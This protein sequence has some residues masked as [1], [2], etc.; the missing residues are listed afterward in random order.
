MLAGLLL[1]GGTGVWDAIMGGKR[2]ARDRAIA[3]KTAEWKSF[4]GNSIP[5]IREANP[6]ASIM[7]GLAGG[8][9]LGNDFSNGLSN[10]TMSDL[11]QKFQTDKNSMMSQQAQW[12]KDHPDATPTVALGQASPGNGWMPI[13]PGMPS[14]W[15][16]PYNPYRNAPGGKK[17]SSGDGE[18]ATLV[19][20]S[21]KSSNF[22]GN[23]PYSYSRPATY[24]GQYQ[25]D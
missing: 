17:D 23:S 2:E 4:T 14:F 25:F 7:G 20:P 8:M 5:S 10:A 1:G 6:V 22:N 3:S 24:L 15:T 18:K 16:T 11:M 9:M 19:S 13:Y 12:W 21:K